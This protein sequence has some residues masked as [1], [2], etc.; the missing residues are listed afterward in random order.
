[1]PLVVVIG[2]SAIGG[3]GYYLYTEYENR[4]KLQTGMWDLEL[5]MSEKYVLFLKGE[6]DETDHTN[7]PDSYWFEVDWFDVLLKHEADNDYSTQHHWIF[8]KDDEIIRIAYLGNRSNSPTINGLKVGDPIEK[9]VEKLGE[10]D[11]TKDI[12]EGKARRYY[13]YQFNSWYNAE[14]GKITAILVG[15]A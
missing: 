2:L 15:S 9:M 14:R 4:P 10:P 5:G 1:M 12:L 13:Y 3:G 11:E 7:D 6:P 8:L